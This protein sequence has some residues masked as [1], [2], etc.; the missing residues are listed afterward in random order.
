MSGGNWTLNGYV[1]VESRL[2]VTGGRAFSPYAFIV[3]NY[4]RQYDPGSLPGNLTVSGGTLWSGTLVVGQYNSGVATVVDHGNIWANTVRL[5]SGEYPYS[6]GLGTGVLNLNG[7]ASGRGVLRTAQVYVGFNPGPA[8]INFDGGILQAWQNQTDYISGFSPGEVQL[9]AGG[10]FIDTSTYSV[11]ISTPLQGVGG[12]TKMGAG[13]LTL[14][15]PN[16]YLGPT[17]I[18]AGTLAL[19]GGA[20]F[21]GSSD[22]NLTGSTA[23]LELNSGETIGSLAGVAGSVVTL[24]S[25]SIQLAGNTSTTFAGSLRSG[26]SSSGLIKG[27]TGTLTLSGTNTYTG[28]TTISTGLLVLSGGSALSDM[29]DV[30]VV[31]ATATLQVNT[32]ESIGSLSGGVGSAVMLGNGVALTTGLNNAN[33]VF[34]GNISGG[35][36]ASGLTKAGAGVLTLSGVNTYTGPTI[37]IAGAMALSGGM[38]LSNASAVSLTG[39]TAGLLVNANETISS[40]AGVSGS[41]V[42]LGNG[43]VLT[44]GTGNANTTFAG[45]I[46]GGN[47]TSAMVKAGAGVLTLTGANTFAGGVSLNGGALSLGSVGALGSTGIISFGGGTL[48]FSGGNTGDYSGRFSAAANQTYSIDTNGQRVSFA[49]ALTSPGGTLTKL[50]NGTLV[51]NGANSYTGQT[52]VNGGIL[53]LGSAGALGAS[54]ALSFGGGTL[55]YSANNTIDYSDRF[56]TAA[57]QTYSIDTNGQRVSFASALTSPG[58]TLTKLGNGTLVLNGAN[59]YTG[60]TGVNG[61]I[62]LLGSAG[63]LGASSTLSFGGGTLQYSA[64]NTIDYSDRFSAAANQAYSI[65]TN[66]Q[67]VSFASALTSPGGTLTKIGAGTLALTAASTYTGLTTIAA[68][69]LALSGT[70]AVGLASDVSLAGA[71]AVL[72]VSTNATIGSLAG[73]PSASTV[74][75]GNGAVLTTGASNASTAFSGSITGGN[76][77]SG[78]TKVG[79][80]TFTL[81]GAN[82]YTGPTTVIAGT[83][84]LSGGAAVS[85]FSDVSLVGNTAVL[86]VN[87]SKTISALA[88]TQ[89]GSKV[90]LGNGAVLTIGGGNG[91]TTFSG[92]ISGGNNTSGLTKTGAGIF[93]LTGTNTYTGPTTVNAG[94]LALAGGAAL[95]DATDVSLAGPTAVLQVSANETIGSLAGNATGGLVTL[96]N[97]V[98][99][100]TGGDNATTIFAGAITGGNGTSGLVKMGAGTL[101]LSGA[102]TYTGPT[103]ISAGTLAMAGGAAIGDTSDISLTHAGT[104]LLVTTGE[105]IGSLAGMAGSVVTLGNGTILTV[106]RSNGSAIFAGTIGGGNSTSGL[107]KTGTGILTINGTN[108]YTGPT[109]IDVG[110]LVVAGG[111]A[112][113]DS[114]DVSLTGASAVLMVNASESVG[115]LAGVAGSTVTLGSGA[116]LTVGADNANT[117]F[118][119]LLAGS[120]VTTGLTKLGAGTLGFAGGSVSTGT[121]KVDGGALAIN[122][123][124]F[125]DPISYLGS[126]SGSRGTVTFSGGIWTTNSMNIG[127]VGSGTLVIA[128]GRLIAASD[129]IGGVSGGNGTVYISGGD[130]NTGNALQIGLGGS[131]TLT[132][133]GGNVTS[134]LGYVGRNSGASGTVV[135][136]G[137][138]WSN[139]IDLYVGNTGTGSLTIGTGGLVAVGGNLVLAQSAGSAGSLSLAAGGTLQVGGSNAIQVGAGTSSFNWAGGTL[140]VVGANLTAGLKASLADATTSTFDTNGLA[141]TCTGNLAGSGALAKVGAGTLML[142]GA[143]TYSGGTTVTAGTLAVGGNGTLGGAGGNVTVVGGAVLDVSGS[144][145]GVGV[146][147]LT[148]NGTVVLGSKNMTVGTDY[149]NAAFGTGNSFNRHGN[150]TGTGSINA[151]GNATQSLTGG[152]ITGGNTTT[153][154][155][156]LGSIHEGD[157][158]TAT[159]SVANAGATGPALRG[160]V[161]TTTDGGSLTDA[162]LSGAGVTATNYGPIATG[163]SSPGLGVTFT[164]SSPGALTG[165]TVA[166]VSNFDNV[167]GQVLTVNGAVYRYA[168]GSG[169][170]AGVDLGIVHVGDVVTDT[171]TITNSAAATGGFTESL[172]AAFGTLTNAL[173][174]SGSVS[175]LAPGASSSALKLTLNTAAA[176]TLTAVPVPVNF[177]SQAVLGSL[178]GNTVLAPQTTAV[179]AQVNNYAAPA[180]SL[181]S[182]GATLSLLSPTIAVLDFGQVIVGSGSVPVQVHL[183]NAAAAPADALKGSFAVPNPSAAF[184]I[185][186]A[187]DFTNLAAGTYQS[188]QVGLNTNQLGSFSELLTLD[189]TSQNGSGYTG[190]LGQYQLQITGFV[191]IPEPG[192][193]AALLGAAF[194]LWAA[195]RRRRKA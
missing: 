121:V 175:G 115:S 48:Q 77:T 88:G 64:N 181:A 192:A 139:S 75:L 127:Y 74:I 69:T 46:T 107:L 166:V 51:L 21:N 97:G 80:G 17:V 111:A 110:T 113:S 193:T 146:G 40:L 188:F 195:C 2:I 71:T 57:N 117:A 50:G 7:S 42:T 172:G 151:G 177:T 180:Y 29:S 135:V 8:T 106:G 102:N 91:N 38:A 90:T 56:I 170:P 183:G 167:T 103:I 171:L 185:T 100:T 34:A 16:T 55:Q 83:L 126:V 86:Q 43:V 5:A 149:N 68:G 99:L 9:L 157:T 53:L 98:V 44:T 116:I 45:A 155:I 142:S 169:L 163:A 134:K 76:S 30:M 174:G 160:A 52:G 112:I 178:L 28:P 125:T 67:T 187:S 49:S 109:T 93:T 39:P 138:N 4:P 101:T 128:G 78:L 70:A 156:A 123:G 165:Q 89:A 72:Q 179:T 194:L 158:V 36:N 13:T 27:G 108:T 133:T 105:T 94:T 153:P 82:S 85:D 15:G 81:N 120:N 10:A 148:D 14:S 159:Y 182:G 137:G 33:T 87:T 96:D 31:D 150:V 79:T 19:A 20:V 60:Q 35:D 131:G 184:F 141:A 145:A 164:G 11:G 191:A 24:D 119:G 18:T 189:G 144:T 95:S 143:N 130:W 168:T 62:L 66:G 140:Q 147:A 41:S 3:D 186:G 61:G 124:T 23:F 54:S 92:S 114:S 73:T 6:Q 104:G 58:G 176:T 22:F 25:G 132:I 129:G 1:N 37:I 152:N 162:R 47:E 154:T 136:V 122:G 12:L 26:N 84:V 63:A 173:S 161:Q 59:S 118:S 190:S 65:D 32:S